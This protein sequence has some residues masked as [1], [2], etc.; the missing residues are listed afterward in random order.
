MITVILLVGGLIVFGGLTIASLA[1]FIAEEWFLALPV[2]IVYIIVLAVVVGRVDRK[3][4][5]AYPLL[6]NTVTIISKFHEKSVDGVASVV[7]TRNTYALVFEFSSGERKKLSVTAEQYALVRE[8]DTGI[9]SYKDLTD[10]YMDKDKVV[11][12]LQFVNFQPQL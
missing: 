1:G 8:G 2:G 9:L 6:T 3:K 12:G 11:T 10:V 5:E 4:I 7:S